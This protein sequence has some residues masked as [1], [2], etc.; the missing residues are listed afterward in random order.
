MNSHQDGV[1]INRVEV[2]DHRV[3]GS[4]RMLVLMPVKAEISMQDDGQTLKVFVQDT[5]ELADLME[6]DRARLEAVREIICKLAHDLGIQSIGLALD[7]RR[8]VASEKALALVFEPVMVFRVPAQ[9]T[10]YV[11]R[12]SQRVEK[13]QYVWRVESMDKKHQH[14]TADDT[15]AAKLFLETWMIESLNS[16][17]AE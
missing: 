16:W 8:D 10:L 5:T 7:Y 12:H 2:I 4:G 6:Q 15:E 1:V 13:G 3:G 11:G 17:K 14:A 9:G